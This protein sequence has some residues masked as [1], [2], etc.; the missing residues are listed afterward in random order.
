MFAAVAIAALA[1]DLLG[2]IGSPP[3]AALHAVR[4]HLRRRNLLGLLDL[5]Y[6][7]DPSSSCSSFTSSS[8]SSL[9]D[10]HDNE[11]S[12]MASPCSRRSKHDLLSGACATGRWAAEEAEEVLEATCAAQM[13]GW[14][15]LTKNVTEW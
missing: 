4:S 5:L 12:C 15:K 13:D 3:A 8:A 10:D 7:V 2:F 6:G 14:M 11:R 1:S 9:F